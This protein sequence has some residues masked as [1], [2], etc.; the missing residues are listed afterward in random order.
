MKRE[1]RLAGLLDRYEK[2]GLNFARSIYLVGIRTGSERG[3]T[4]VALTL[5]TEVPGLD[6]RYTTDGSDPRLA[7]GA[8]NAAAS[9]YAGP[10]TLNA[11]TRI[12]A[13]R[14]PSR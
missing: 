7:G 14:S 3:G 1:A 13:R 10:L 8:I 4:R 11:S 12:R 6:I 5:E 9:V 2:A